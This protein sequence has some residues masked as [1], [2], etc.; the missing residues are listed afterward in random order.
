VLLP[1]LL[2]LVPLLLVLLPEVLP[3][4]PK[5]LLPL[6]LE[7]LLPELVLLPEVLPLLPK[8]L[9]PLLVL[10]PELLLPDDEPPSSGK[11]PEV[12]PAH[13]ATWTIAATA[14]KPTS[15]TADFLRRMVDLSNL[16]A[17]RAPKGKRWPSGR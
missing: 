7:V 1:E 12:C 6:L 11:P 4:L 10:L 8:P 5:P 9:L 17:R 3:L 16:V 2:V 15:E 13:P 14:V